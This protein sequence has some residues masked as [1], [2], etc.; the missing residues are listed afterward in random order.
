MIVFMSPR[1]GIVV[2]TCII[3]ILA[4]LQAKA[5]ERNDDRTSITAHLFANYGSRYFAPIGFSLEETNSVMQGAVVVGA[6]NIFLPGDGVDA[7]WWGNEGFDGGP[8]EMDWGFGYTIPVRSSSIRLG[9]DHYRYPDGKLGTPEDILRLTFRKGTIVDVVFDAFWRVTDGFK[10][11]Y[12]INLGVSK[13][14]ST[15]L[16]QSNSM[17]V[18]P[19]ATSIYNEELWGLSGYAGTVFGT[20]VE[21]HR[22]NI[23]V[24]VDA[25]QLIKS[26]NH[27]LEHREIKNQTVFQVGVST[28]IVLRD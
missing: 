27:L 4:S 25:M 22:E 28:D 9:Y 8:S 23:T 16:S 15:T 26:G 7:F 10:K 6:G 21:L 11:Q 1:I 20:K 5:Q 3:T 13:S 24:F 18:T 19:R 14:Y 12:F 17:T 2:L